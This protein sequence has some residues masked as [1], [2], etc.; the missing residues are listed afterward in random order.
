MN[1]SFKCC[2][3]KGLLLTVETPEGGAMW[4]QRKFRYSLQMLLMLLL[5]SLFC[6]AAATSL[7]AAETVVDAADTMVVINAADTAA[8]ANQAGHQRIVFK[9]PIAIARRNSGVTG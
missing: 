1:F 9:R 5:M 6:V 2:Q 3:E 8:T 4:N 7:V